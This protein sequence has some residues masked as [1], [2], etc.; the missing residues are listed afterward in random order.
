M[1]V[2]RRRIA[3]GSLQSDLARRGGEEIAAAH[4]LRDVL[5]RIVDDDRELVREHPVGALDDEVAAAGR[6]VLLDGSPQQIVERDRLIGNPKADRS[7]GAPLQSVAAGAGIHRLRSE[8]CRGGALQ[9]GARASAVEDEPLGAQFHQRRLVQRDPLRLH[10][11]FAVPLQS[12]ST[13]RAEDV[14]RRAG[15]DARRVEILNPH[16]PPPARAASE[17]PRS[18]GRDEAA[19]VQRSGGRRG[20]AADGLRRHIRGAGRASSCRADCRPDRCR[21]LPP[22]TT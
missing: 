3:E 22:R 21:S 13:E 15:N 7:R 18:D 4:D 16:Q 8:R 2:H 19:E 5:R 6:Q 1:R 14:V 11:H 20:E 10:G 17:H 12:V 9:I